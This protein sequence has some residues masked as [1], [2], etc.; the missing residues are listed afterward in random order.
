MVG[1]TCY[2]ESAPYQYLD[3]FYNGDGPYP[4][5]V[6]L[7]LSSS[8]LPDTGY[9]CFGPGVY[10]WYVTVSGAIVFAS[11]TGTTPDAGTYATSGVSLGLPCANNW[12]SAA[13][14][15]TVTTP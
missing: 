3:I 6:R 10:V 12:T 1:A 7:T 2:Y 13:G 11:L 15:L 9:G 8:C 5:D 4:E 14:T